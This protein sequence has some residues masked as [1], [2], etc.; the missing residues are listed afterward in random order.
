MFFSDG[1]ESISG[2]LFVR[3]DTFPE[4]NETFI[5]EITRVFG[6]TIGSPSTLKLTITANDEP[7]GFVQFSQ[8]GIATTYSYLFPANNYYI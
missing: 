2:T 6:P 8:V 1:V 7:H 5:V 4:G 3:S